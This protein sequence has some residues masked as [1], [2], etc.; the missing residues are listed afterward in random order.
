M[1]IICLDMDGVCN[2]DFLINQWVLKKK[3]ELSYTINEK[4]ML[5]EIRRLYRKEFCDMTELV[6]PELAEKISYICEETDAK[7]LWSSTWR[8]LKK[9]EDI[10][11]ARDM[12]N[13]RGLPGERLIGY[14]PDL[15]ADFGNEIRGNEIRSWLFNNIYGDIEK[16]AVIDDRS[17]AGFFLPKNSKFFLIDSYYGIRNSDVEKIIDYL[18]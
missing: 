11:V 13:R 16:C 9:Y 4:D 6:F 12:F 2:S 18:K 17:D 10:D 8:N 14:T 7:I 3:K 5:Q 15:N 1:K